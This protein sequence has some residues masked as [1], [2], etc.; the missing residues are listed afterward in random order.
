MVDV[1]GIAGDVCVLNTLKD[2][3]AIYGRSP[4]FNVLEEYCPSI[5]GG[6]ALREFLES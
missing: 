1:C 6:T 2:G 4:Q 3:I 5:D